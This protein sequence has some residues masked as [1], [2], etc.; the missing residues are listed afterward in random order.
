MPIYEYSCPR[1]GNFETTQRITEPPLKRCPTCKSKVERMLSRT[2]FILKG[3][4]WYATDYG[5]SGKS[6]G[7]S[8][9]DSASANGS[10]TASSSDG[11]SADKGGEKSASSGAGDKSTSAK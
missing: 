1:C 2:S 11:G 3:S 8:K 4:G 5:R 7:E 10:A 6:G 9:S